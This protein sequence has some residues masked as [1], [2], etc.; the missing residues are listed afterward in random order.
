MPAAVSLAVGYALLVVLFPWELIQRAEF[1]DFLAYVDEFNNRT[2]SRREIYQLAGLKQFFTFEVLW[3]ELVRWLTRMTGEA[4]TALRLI[5]FF[6]LSVWAVYL[7]RRVRLGMALL[8][9]FNPTSIDVAMSGIRNGLAWALVILGLSTRTRGT[10]AA[11]FIIALFIH[12]STAV[13]LVLYYGT[14]WAVRVLRGRILVAVG[15]S[16]G[17]LFGLALTVGTQLVFAAIGDRRMDEGYAVGGGSFLQASVW[18]ILLYLQCTSGREYVK[19]HLFVIALLA[20][21]ETMN[22]FIPWSFRIWGAFLPVI[23]VSLGQLPARKRQVALYAYSGYLVL[24]WIYWTKLLN[25]WV[26]A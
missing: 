4:S 20:W 14:R 9:L 25:Y 8:F 2:I 26:S 19:R 5:S 6:V 1:S 10:R 18:A 3:D 15:I 13:L 21:Y 17:V 23:A 24:Q 22:P 16:L 11:L 7:L 12:S